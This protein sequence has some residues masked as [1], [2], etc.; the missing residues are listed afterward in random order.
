MNDLPKCQ[1][2]KAVQ[3]AE[4][5]NRATNEFLGVL[6]HT[7]EIFGINSHVSGPSGNSW[8]TVA[9]AEFARRWRPGEDDP[10][11]MALEILRRSRFISDVIC[12]AHGQA[13]EI[14]DRER[15]KA[16]R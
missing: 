15:T 7:L 6:H 10:A 4:A 2:C 5:R 11:S 1:A 12:H 8:V 14:L 13:K 16:T 3:D 9:L